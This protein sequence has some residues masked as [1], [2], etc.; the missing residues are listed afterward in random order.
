MYT[1]YF[2]VREPP[3]TVAPDP[4]FV[5]V[6]RASQQAYATLLSGIHE[7]KGF[8]FVTGEAG[9]GKTT[10]LRRVIST[11]EDPLRCVF[12]DASTLSTVT[13]DELLHCLCKELGLPEDERGRLQ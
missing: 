2:A 9:T 1:T 10:L 4:R 12:V 13:F 3:F 6:N 11:L 5:Y 7:R 8:L